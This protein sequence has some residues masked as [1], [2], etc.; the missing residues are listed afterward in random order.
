MSLDVYLE[1]EGAA[2]PTGSGIFVREGGV[3]REV[4]FE[5]WNAMHP[6]T[7]PYAI[8]REVGER[9]DT[10]FHANIT[11]NLNTMAQAAGLYELLWRPD[12]LGLSKAKFLIEPMEVGLRSLKQCPDHF[13]KYNPKNGWGNYDQLLSFVEKYLAACKEWPDAEIIIS[14]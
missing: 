8:Q 2:V 1:S 10:V 6:G 4:T 5:E 14:R 3:T 9:T 7:D 12:E 13:K 11:H